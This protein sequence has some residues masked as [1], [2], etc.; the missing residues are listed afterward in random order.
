MN[1]ELNV[2]LVRS[3]YSLNVGYTARAMTNM[4]ANRLILIDPKCEMDIDARNGAAGA[5]DKLLKSTVHANWQ[6][7]LQKENEGVLWAFCGKQNKSMSPHGYSRQVE[8]VL[9]SP[10]PINHRRHFLIFGP[11][12]HG[13]NQDDLQHVHQVTTLPTHSEFNS[14]NLSH[15]VL[16][17]LH[18]FMDSVQKIEAPNLAKN[19]VDQE[20][21]SDAGHLQFPDQAIR[22]WLTAIGFQIDER[23]RNAFTT[24]KRLMLSH[25]PSA[26]E[27]KLFEAIVQQTIRKLK[28][29]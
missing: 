28:S 14:L 22:D 1:I 27:L 24:L 11:E 13:L 21:E 25:L 3:I 18:I 20:N 8:L 9:K 2:V 19:R 16:L 29:K 15:A 7:F 4:G 26:K 10:S 6:E 12:N 17:A 5:Q 23:N